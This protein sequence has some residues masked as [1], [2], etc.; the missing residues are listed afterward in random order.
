[1]GC[2]IPPAD[3]IRF[4]RTSDKLRNTFKLLAKRRQVKYMLSIIE[5]TNRLITEMIDV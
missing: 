5:I 2:S 4:G 1:M 3:S